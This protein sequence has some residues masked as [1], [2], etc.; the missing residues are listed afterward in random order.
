MN[1]RY[2]MEKSFEVDAEDEAEAEELA[3]IEFEKVED[4]GEYVTDVKMHS[5][6]YTVEGILKQQNG[7]IMADSSTCL[8]AGVSSAT[9]L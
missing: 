7:E 8:K 9:I 5:R 1:I 6:R 3:M 2:L 4:D